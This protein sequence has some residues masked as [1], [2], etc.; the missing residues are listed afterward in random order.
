MRCSSSRIR[1]LVLSSM[2]LVA[3]SWGVETRPSAAEEPAAGKT[4][5]V[6]QR[7][8]ESLPAMFQARI[9][10]RKI[11]LSKVPSQAS[12]F[13]PK[14]LISLSRRWP[15]G[16]TVKI[17]FKGGDKALHKKID[18]AVSEWTRYANLKFDFGVNPAT[19]EYRK[20]K[21]TDTTFTA[22][23]RVSFDKSGYYSLIGKDSVDP[24]IALP[25]SE[26]LN[27]EGFDQSLPPDWMGTARHEFG[28]AISF[29][30][31]HQASGACDFRF[32]DD[33]GYV[34]TTD[35]FGQ[36]INDSAG[37]RPGL[38]TLLGGPPNNW[39]PAVVDF[40]LKDLPPSSAFAPGPFDKDSI[41]KYFFPSFM[42]IAGEHSPCY[43]SAEALDLSAGDKKGAAAVYPRESAAIMADKSIRAKA[44]DVLSNAQSV[45]KSMKEEFN[46][47]KA[48]LH[49]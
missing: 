31:E 13:A 17:A 18:D 45:P 28:H 6:K 48:A 37:R 1:I 2:F 44:Y 8:L 39:P 46:R 33:A 14:A 41:M 7:P 5:G 22:D 20:W 30:H 38:Y 21:T 49:D 35:D 19:G 12:G 32:E 25:G 34:P 26:S 11:T 9:E 42:F 10:Q 16:H 47:L 40:N 3:T 4:K 24:L 27:L 43:T 36:F 15:N 29:E 23:V